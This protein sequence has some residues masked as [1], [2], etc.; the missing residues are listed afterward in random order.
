MK[1]SI[2]KTFKYG[3]LAIVVILFAAIMV[4]GWSSKSDIKVA[5]IITEYNT[6]HG[7]V[8]KTIDGVIKPV[9]GFSVDSTMNE[10][11][12]SL[13][14]SKSNLTTELTLESAFTNGYPIEL[15][16]HKLPWYKNIFMSKGTGSVFV[17][18]VYVLSNLKIT[19]PST[20]I[21]INKV[22]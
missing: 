3:F 7:F 1:K 14:K 13:D 16:G 21:V 5:G 18:S 6:H 4:Q 2:K 11:I 12:F 8:V 20:D 19:V 15:Y 17:D 9:P 10:T 22:K